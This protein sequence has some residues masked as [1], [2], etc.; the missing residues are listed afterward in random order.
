MYLYFQSCRTFNLLIYCELARRLDQRVSPISHFCAPR[1]PFQAGTM[2]AN[3]VKTKWQSAPYGLTMMFMAA[4]FVNCPAALIAKE[5]GRLVSPG[6]NG[7]LQYQPDAAGNRIPDFSHCGYMGGGVAIPSA[8][9]RITL[10]PSGNTS[11]DTARIQG[12]IDKLSKLP[13]GRNSIRGAL[14]LKK[15][16]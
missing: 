7:K 4:V 15:G 8:P 13:V 1:G 12:A 11:D 10:R 14:L 16:K 6:A 2:P 9:V 3:R 5:Q